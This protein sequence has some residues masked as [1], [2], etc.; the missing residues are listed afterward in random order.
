MEFLPFRLD[1]L[2]TRD[3][4]SSIQLQY[5]ICY[6]LRGISAGHSKK[7]PHRDIKPSNILL[8]DKYVPR[9]CDWGLSTDKREGGTKMFMAPELFDKTVEYK[10]YFKADSWS[11][12]LVIFFMFEKRYP[13]VATGCKVES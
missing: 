10:D 8:D 3:E 4:L 2:I 5:L 6:I 12:G 11:V 13:V 7:I 1:N 9:I